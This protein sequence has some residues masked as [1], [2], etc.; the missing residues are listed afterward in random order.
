MYEIPSCVG[1]S[2][3]TPPSTNGAT[4]VSNDSP[5]DYALL[6]LNENPATVPGINPLFNGWDATFSPGSNGVGIHHPS[7]DVR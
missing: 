5:S 4:L 1:G 3:F 6:M 2:D 7:G